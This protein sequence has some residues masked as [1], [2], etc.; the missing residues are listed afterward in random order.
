MTCEAAETRTPDCFEPS[1]LKM[2]RL[3]LGAAESR[4]MWGW[5]EILSGMVA[6]S[7]PFFNPAELA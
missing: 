1:L 2:R 5:A 4:L 6:S 7:R 3:A